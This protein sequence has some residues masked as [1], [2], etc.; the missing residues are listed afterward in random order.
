MLAYGS[1]IS[2]NSL[3]NGLT[4]VSVKYFNKTEHAA[5]LEHKLK[6]SIFYF[7]NSVFNISY[8]KN[9]ILT[10]RDL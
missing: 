5:I 6:E 3:G 7:Y 9:K 10:Y 4:E 8:N 1:G 2:T